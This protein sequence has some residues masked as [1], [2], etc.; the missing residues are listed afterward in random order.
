MAPSPRAFNLYDMV[1]GS[2]DE[3][4]PRSFDLVGQRIVCAGMRLSP[5]RNSA[6]FPLFHF[7]RPP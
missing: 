6:H 4:S 7:L 3:A 5:L 2:R 1:V